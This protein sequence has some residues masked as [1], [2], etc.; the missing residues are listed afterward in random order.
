MDIHLQ[1]TSLDIGD[2]GFDCLRR[3]GL[4]DMFYEGNRNELSDDL[5]GKIV[6][7]LLVHVEEIAQEIRTWRGKPDQLAD[8]ELA[9]IEKSIGTCPELF[10]T[11]AQLSEFLDNPQEMND[12]GVDLDDPLPTIDGIVE[13]W[14]NKGR[15]PIGVAMTSSP[16]DEWKIFA[17]VDES[18][19]VLEWM[20]NE[21]V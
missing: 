6:K 13:P 12:L 17:L 1:D 16:V 20:L 8:D 19:E 15:N 7:S 5:G 18:G 2:D 3:F 4:A 11:L 10:L 14:R 21:E 9:E